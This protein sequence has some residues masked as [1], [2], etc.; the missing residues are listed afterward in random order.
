[1]NAECRHS[2][3]AAA[4]VADELSPREQ[5][6]FEAHIA[7]CA[8]CRAAVESTRRV[9]GR[10][11]SAPQVE[12]AH[13]LAPVIFARL[14]EEPREL[15]RPARWPRIA[16]IAA[17]VTLF[18][19]GAF[20]THFKKSAPP[21]Q[22]I[23]AVADEHAASVARALD[24]FCQNQEPDGSW[25]A[26]KW[27]GN[28]RFEVALTALPTLALFR[29]ESLTP[30]GSSAVASA[31]R[32]LQA[33]QTK[34]GSF[35]PNF[36]GASYNQSIA[37][38]ALLHAY[39]RRPDAALKRSLDAALAN[40]LTRQTSDGGWGYLHSRLADRSI[41]EWHI[42]A[43]ELASAL[44]WENARANLVRGRTWL[45]AHPHP[46][47]DAEEPAD[48][49]SAIL[50]RTEDATTTNNAKLD[51]YRAY[52]LT[53]ALKRE[54]NESSRQRLAAI[55]QALLLQQ[56]SDGSDSGSWPADDRWG[57]A[58]GRLYST[59]LASLSMRDR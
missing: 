53:A 36:Q 45:A 46:R 47:T 29:A 35:G 6:D 57:P 31:T 32:W 30:Q 59:A 25:N 9:I 21:T 34:A 51:F 42:E 4:Y 52:F 19:G 2:T 10:L 26:E 23:V 5:A 16:A 17:L 38:L 18:A 8:E 14:R 27:G 11:R 13:D 1:M 39:Q 41:T 22:P 44:G 28:R 55:R 48:S 43:L 50:G 33:Q 15:P 24:W 49:P 3:D 7:T 40:I 54:H 56:V 20:V 37:T 58:G 12:S